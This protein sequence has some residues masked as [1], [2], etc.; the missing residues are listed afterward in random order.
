MFLELEK[1]K[2]IASEVSVSAV[3][4]FQT[5]ALHGVFS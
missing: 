3:D 4:L 5:S 1:F 2:S